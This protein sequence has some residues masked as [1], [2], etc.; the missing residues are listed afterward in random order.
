MISFDTKAAASLVKYALSLERPRANDPRRRLTSGVVLDDNGDFVQRVTS[1]PVDY[2]GGDAHHAQAVVSGRVVA[3]LA[4]L[5]DK[6]AIVRMFVPEVE[7][8]VDL[9]DPPFYVAPP[10]PPLPKFRIGTRPTSK[11]LKP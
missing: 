4:V 7:R 2:C 5:G 9:V 6:G 3:R 1:T 10:A 11:R 8:L